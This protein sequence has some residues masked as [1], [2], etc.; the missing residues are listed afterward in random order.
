MLSVEEALHEFP[1]AIAALKSNGS[2]PL[3]PAPRTVD[4]MP[5]GFVAKAAPAGLVSAA[6]LPTP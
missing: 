3:S 1:S 5:N 6:T 4:A 2:H